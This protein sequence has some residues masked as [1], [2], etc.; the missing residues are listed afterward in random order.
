MGASEIRAELQRRW[1]ESPA[2]K[3]CFAILEYLERVP[4]EQLQMLTFGTLQEAVGKNAVDPELI[5]ALNILV[6]SRIAA[7]DAKVLLIDELEDEY[8]ISPTELSEARSSGALIHPRTGELI[9]EFESKL[10]PFFVP[11]E[12]FRAA[13]R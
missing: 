6:S 1:Q 9:E 5:T 4:D 10:V 11:S 7:L 12:S 8:E 3:V 13:K 2:L